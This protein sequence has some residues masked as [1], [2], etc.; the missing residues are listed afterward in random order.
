MDAW[1][2]QHAGILGW[3]TRKPEPRA[4]LS[5][6]PTASAS[7]ETWRARSRP[8]DGEARAQPSTTLRCELGRRQTMR[9]GPGRVRTSTVLWLRHLALAVLASARQLDLWLD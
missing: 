3:P 4:G 1:I 5:I 8:P 6:E 2:G 7:P 9:R